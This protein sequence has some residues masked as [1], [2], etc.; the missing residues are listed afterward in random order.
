MFKRRKKILNE[1]EI[2]SIKIMTNFAEGKIS[3]YEF[4]HEYNNNSV[5]K[6]I[7]NNDE[8]LPIRNKP[9]LYDNLNINNIIHRCEIFRVVKVYFLRR[10]ME[11]NFYNH[12]SLLYSELLEIIP[13]YIDINQYLVDNIKNIQLDVE[14]KEMKAYIKKFVKENYQY[15]KYPPRWLQSPEWPIVDGKPARFIKQNKFP[16]QMIWY[17]LEICY[18]FEDETG[19]VIIVKQFT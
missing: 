5:L 4:W 10:N 16:Y 9:F 6:D 3:V 17:D 13:T 15:M 1:E 7:I 8:K 14:T 12:D 2:N 19:N 18:Y 11:L